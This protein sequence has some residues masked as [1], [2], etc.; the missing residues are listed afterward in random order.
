[1]SQKI[2]PMELHSL[3]FCFEEMM[4]KPPYNFADFTQMEDGGYRNRSVQIAWAMLR[5]GYLAGKAFKES[6]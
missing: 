6:K 1:M 4:R 2:P 5:C 3:R